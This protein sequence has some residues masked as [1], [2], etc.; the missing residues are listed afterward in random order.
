VVRL[1]IELSVTKA[2]IHILLHLWASPGDFLHSR[3]E[4]GFAEQFYEMT[5]AVL[6][7]G[8]PAKIVDVLAASVSPRIS[9][10]RLCRNTRTQVL[11][12]L[13]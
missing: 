9:R 10:M 3:L 1:S 2:A 13:G 8:K 7:D 4:R 5:L 12:D 6:P 11:P